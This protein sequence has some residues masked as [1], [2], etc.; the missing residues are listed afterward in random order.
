MDFLSC[1][2]S[3]LLP[4][5]MLE[6]PLWSERKQKE[7]MKTTSIEDHSQSVVQNNTPE[8]IPEENSEEKENTTEQSKLSDDTTQCKEDPK[9]SVAS[10]AKRMFPS[11]NISRRK[12]EVKGLS[13]CVLNNIYFSFYVKVLFLNYVV[14]TFISY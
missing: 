5:G 1:V 12:K 13:L 2:E 10:K 14:A 11:F 7:E 4:Y 9:P 6:P 8:V 3:S